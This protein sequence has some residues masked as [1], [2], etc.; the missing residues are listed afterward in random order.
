MIRHLRDYGIKVYR[1]DVKNKPQYF[2]GCTGHRNLS[3]I[4]GFDEESVRGSVRS[5]LRKLKEKYS[6]KL[7]CGFGDG[8]D[9]L[10]AEEALKCGVEVIAVLPCE[11]KEF[12]DEHA[13]GGVKFMQLL[14]QCKEVRIKPSNIHRY[15]ETSSYIVR[16]CNELMALWDGKELPLNDSAG[17]EINRGGT[18]DT[19]LAAEKA[20]KTI[21]RFA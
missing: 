7:F 9:L 10:F 3:R 17:N 6:L 13:D 21:K 4:E 16:Q 11:W 15:A 5:Y 14:G 2:L 20:N 19:I 8:A 12:M 1:L 18:F